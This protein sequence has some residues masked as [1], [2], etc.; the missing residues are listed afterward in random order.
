MCWNTEQLMLNTFRLMLIPVQRRQALFTNLL[1]KEEAKEKTSQF[2]KQQSIVCASFSYH[3]RG[4]QNNKR[5]TRNPSTA[6]VLDQT[7]GPQDSSSQKI[8][9]YKLYRQKDAQHRLFS[10]LS[11]KKSQGETQPPSP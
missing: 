6:R 10:P 5:A 9:M 8:S 3:A 4:R 2:G 1:Q 11:P 7:Q